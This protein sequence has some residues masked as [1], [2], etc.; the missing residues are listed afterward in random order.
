MAHP[1]FQA[2]AVLHNFIVTNPLI[3]IKLIDM[4]SKLKEK[5]ERTLLNKLNEFTFSHETALKR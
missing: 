1:T 2:S 4:R 3:I 5:T